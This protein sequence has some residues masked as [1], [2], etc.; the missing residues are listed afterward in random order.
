MPRVIGID[1]GTVSLDLCGLDD[2]RV[3]LERSIPTAAALADP[4]L[5]VSLIEG[6]VP[7]DLV[8]GP[9]GYGLPVTA[10][11]DLTE[12]DLRLACLSPRGEPGGIGG[13]VSLMRALAHLAAPAVVTP[14]VVHLAS[15]PAHRKVNRVDMGTADKVCAAALAIHEQAAR[16]GCRERDVSLILLELGGAFTAAIAVEGGRIVDGL[17]GSSGPLGATSAGALDAEV[18]FLAERVT[19]EMVF[20]GGAL[21][22]AGTPEAPMETLVDAQ[23]PRG[24]LAWDAYVESA[25]KAV[26]VLA[27]STPAAREVVLSGRLARVPRVRDVLAERL[28]VVHSRMSVSVLEGFGTM[29]KHAAQGAALL[30][31]GL[32][33]GRSADLV[34][35]LGLRQASGTALDHLYL[36]SPAVARARLGIS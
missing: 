32:A 16:R 36:V 3:F 19:K 14:G 27:V 28:S 33:G 34:D 29:A 4:G 25:V 18:A 26:A 22:I 9:S 20:S 35:R 17:G 1:P 6:V 23:A 15:V 7:L 13:L 24:R 2:G 12:T 21:T 8:V 11:R 10:V 5:I 30:A 31:D